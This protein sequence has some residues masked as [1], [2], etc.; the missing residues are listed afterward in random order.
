[1]HRS[2]VP[3]MAGLVLLLLLGLQLWS[4]CRAEVRYQ[5]KV[6]TGEELALTA[7]NQKREDN[8][9]VLYTPVFGNTTRTNPYGVEVAAVPVGRQADRY[10]VSQ[11]TS[12]FTCQYNQN[13]AACGNMA[14]PAKGVVLSATGDKRELLLRLF[15]KGAEFELNTML[16][17]QSRMTLDAINPTPE[18]NPKGSGFPGSRGSNQ[19]LLY[20]PAYGKPTT[21]TNEFG[22]EVTVVDNRVV[23]QEGANSTLPREDNA[24]VLSGHGRARDWLLQNATLGSKIE[25]EDNTLI[26]TVDKD[27]YMYQL[28]AVVQRI[29]QL[30]K[31]ALSQGLRNRIDSLR[32]RA[33]NMSDNEVAQE[34][35]TL[36]QQLT[37]ILWASYPSVPANSVRAVW[38]RP[39]E[40]SLKEIRQSLDMLQQGGFNTIYLETYLHGD[41]IFPSKTFATYNIPQKLPFKL[42]EGTPDLLQLW[43][44]EAHRRGIKVHV[45][46]QTFYAGNRQYDGGMGS[47]LAVYPQWANIQ[48]SAVNKT[49]LPPSTLEAGGYFL[50]PANPEVQA[51]LL[52]LIEEI[53]TRYPVDGFQLDYIRYPASFPSDRF[54]YVATTWGYTPLAR[55]RFKAQNGADPL[56]MTPDE[57]MPLWM[58]WNAFKVSQVDSFVEQAYSR[59]KAKRPQLPVSAAVF[60]K[61]QEATMRKHQNWVTWAQKGWVDALAPMT[62]TSSSEVIAGDTWMM[63]FFVAQPLIVGIFGPF[64][65]NSPSDVL[66]QVWTAFN[67]GAAGVSLFDTA[68]LTQPMVEAL[69]MGLFK[70]A[71]TP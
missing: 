48:R 36:K 5:L 21:E 37:P 65:G 56:D 29:E 25:I 52:T 19:M 54:S 12:V 24:F 61:P 71:T 66:E 45:W 67:A 8:S 31:N 59:I 39:S 68:H 64:N 26:S 4:L 15:P 32:L 18:S 41:P 6:P 50:D 7:V 38:H 27:T 57:N 23:K 47:I 43:L 44:N 55:E 10:R 53:I 2:R 1:M 28:E 51:F 42:K 17:Y 60:P 3:V 40:A 11:V 69:R 16:V 22:F 62:L 46:F 35:L 14:I 34:A 20:N 70:P 30:Q 63:R 9:L 58:A 13:L 49:P 33:Y